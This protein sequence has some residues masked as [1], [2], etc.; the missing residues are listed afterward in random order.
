MLP[1]EWHPD[2][3]QDLLEIVS[4]VAEHNM[5]VAEQLGRL[6]YDS[7]SILSE[8][9]YLYK[10]SERK[11]GWREIVAHPNYLV[12]YRVKDNCVQVDKVVHARQLFPKR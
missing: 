12:F 10:E 8:H 5:H 2:T 4:F 7:A 11:P 1:V 9:P 3:E 6:I